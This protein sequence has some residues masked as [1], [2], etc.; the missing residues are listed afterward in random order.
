[1]DYDAAVAQAEDALAGRDSRSRA[2]AAPSD[3]VRGGASSEEE[4][5]AAEAYHEEL[6]RS[7]AP[8]EAPQ[9]PPLEDWE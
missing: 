5:A 9:P 1:M 7:P 6:A 3:G 4:A 2:L 8:M